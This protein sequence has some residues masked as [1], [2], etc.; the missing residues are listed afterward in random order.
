M[1]DARGRIVPKPIKR[2]YAEGLGIGD[3]WISMY[4]ARRGMM[5]RAIQTSLPGAFSKEIMASTIDNV[6]SG[7]DCGTKEGIT[8]RVD[9]PDV[10]DRY[11]AGNQSVFT[12]NTLVDSSVVQRLRKE[13]VST[14]KVRSPLHCLRPKGTCARCYGVDERGTMPSV[15]DNVGAKAGQT[16][17]EPLVQ[18]VMSS[19]HTGGV[20]GAGADPVGFQR[21]NQLL[22]MPKIVTGSAPLA[23]SDG[24]ITKITKGLAGGYD[25]FVNDKKVHVPHGRKLKVALGGKVDAGD[26]LSD[27]VIKP[28][29]LVKHKGMAKAQE[30]VVNELQKA[31]SG[32]GINLHKKVFETV[33][34]SLGNTTQVLN[35]PNDSDHL[36]GDVISYT[37]AQDYNRNLEI[38][39]PTEE[40][41]GYQLSKAHGPLKKGHTLEAKDLKLLK[42]LGH[43]DLSVTKDAI[44]HAPFLKGMNTLPIL[45]KDWMS[46]LGFRNLSKALT[47]GASQ[48]WKT[49]VRGYHPIPAF[50]HGVTFGKGEEGKY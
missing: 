48:G 34:R 10:I 24:K 6:I 12:H 3:Y 44:R 32:Q 16:I 18:M 20:A 27:G 7:E 23:P 30:Y 35:N 46:A 8:L 1:N 4:G 29:D 41:E 11:L 40:C 49:D 21:V 39:K 31:Y 22:Q 17:S 42:A 38:T 14:V 47:E 37:V 5:D 13:G 45:K 33:V 2:S 19:F 9:D 50:A 15:G 28:Q 26:P 43:K 36:P 25:V